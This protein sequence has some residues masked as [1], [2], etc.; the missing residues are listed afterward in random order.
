MLD[1]NSFDCQYL[2]MRFLCQFG[3]KRNWQQNAFVYDLACK[4][5][6]IAL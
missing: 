2:P 5:K 6:R 3:E 1:I 4:L